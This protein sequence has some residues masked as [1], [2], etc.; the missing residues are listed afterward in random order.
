LSA[1]VFEG[2]EPPEAIPGIDSFGLSG[3]KDPFRISATHP[4]LS[5]QA[6]ASVHHLGRG[7]N[8]SGIG[9][10]T[11]QTSDLGWNIQYRTLQLWSRSELYLY[12]TPD[13]FDESAVWAG[14]L[15]TA[16]R[17][18]PP[19]IQ[20]RF[21]F[22][23]Q[24]AGPLDGALEA[25]FAIDRVPSSYQALCFY[26]CCA[27]MTIL[28]TWSF[29][30][31]MARCPQERL[32]AALEERKRVAREM[33][34]TLLQGCTVI[35]SL[36][37]GLSTTTGNATEFERVLLDSARAQ[38]TSTIEEARRAIWNLRHDDSPVSDLADLLREAVDEIGQ[39]FSFSIR[40]EIVG[41]RSSIDQGIS[42]QLLMI[43]REALFNAGR[44]GDPSEVR[45]TIAF[46][47]KKIRV[48]IEDDGKGFHVNEKQ[49]HFSNFH[50]GLLVMRERL[51]IL[52]G[53]L[54]MRSS[55]GNGTQLRISAPIRR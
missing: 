35:S 22:A 33:H 44:H 49:L 37:E 34:D 25:S 9:D 50:Y 55:P 36:L 17:M 26:I 53:T 47:K 8:Y 21:R 11:Y 39:R 23:G 2:I 51:E 10:L 54:N 31:A 28:I 13:P 29:Y 5:A 7:Q 42:R 41:K 45:L 12:H 27:L 32:Q 30:M 16:Y 19:P 46:E 20:H 15:R 38:T 48:N 6:S 1:D 14:N 18:A 24:D 43:V 3:V 4:I 52:G 40:Y